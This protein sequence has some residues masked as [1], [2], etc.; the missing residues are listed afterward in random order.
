MNAA[1]KQRH[2]KTTLE[3]VIDESLSTI[4][5][6]DIQ[7][8]AH[9]AEYQRGSKHGHLGGQSDD[10]ITK[11]PRR[12]ALGSLKWT[13]PF[14]E[15]YGAKSALSGWTVF[16]GFLALVIM[17]TFQ[18]QYH[19]MPTP[20]LTDT[21]PVTGQPHFSEGNVRRIVHHLS[22]NIGW[23]LVGT[24]EELE[25]KNYLIHELD[26]L[27][28]Q[29]R[30]HG[31]KHPELTLPKMDI[32]VQVG[33]GS[34]RFDFMS[35]VVM[36]MYTN[37]TNIIVRMS[38]GPE[39][40]KNSI[41]LNAHYDTTLGSPGAVD[42][43]LGIGVMME[44]IRVMSLK[45]APSKNSVV[46]LFNG[47]EESLQ[48]A[49]HSFITNHEL[50]D[51]IRAVINLEG[52]GTT[53]PDILFQANSLEMINA[54][55]KVPY[56]HG[57]VLAND[58]FA[59]GLILSDT[60]FRQFVE[61]GNL[62]G[63]DMAV[64]RNSYLYHTHLD[65]EENME[66]GLPQHMGENTLA[67]VEH[68]AEVPIK[69]MEKTTNVVFFDV[70]GLFFVSYTW[71][72]VL[73]SHLLIAGL[74]A[75]S[76]VTQASRPSIR[77]LLS[78]GPSLFASMVVP[79]VSVAFLQAVDK[80]MIWFSHEW[81]GPLIFGPL[82]IASILFVQSL[83]HNTKQSTGT[84][85]LHV[86]SS[87]QIVYTAVMGL[88]TYYGLASSF[89]VA[90][91]ALSLTVG[92]LYNQR[93]TAMW[94]KDG[95]EVHHVDYSTY[96]V[97]TLV[98]TSYLSY[99]IFSLFDLFIPL[100]GR[101]GVDAPVDLMVAV[102][103]GFVFFSYC[104]PAI[105]LSHRFGRKT[106]R[107]MAAFMLLAHVVI[108]LVTSIALSPFDKMHP[109]RVFVQHLRNMTSGESKLYIAHADPG[110]FY[111]PYVTDL[112]K[113]FGVES[114]YRSGASNPTDWHSIYPFNQFLDSYTLDTTSYIKSRTTNKTIADTTQPLTHFVH[115]APRLYAENISFDPVK[116]TRRLTVLCTHPDYIWTVI[117][118]DT[119]LVSWSL[120]S[121]TPFEYP[122]HY[123]IRHVGGYVSDGWRV[124]LEY[125]ASSIDDKLRVELTALETEGWG[126]DEER[127]L[128]GSGDVGVMRQ[129]RRSSPDWVSITSF[130]AVVQVFEL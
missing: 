61:Y 82:S 38:C 11:K 116:G 52:C 31:L 9:L 121:S 36:K 99:M 50:K 125:K 65:L 64:Y 46:F 10:E 41:L 94:T 24:P 86:L 62:T 124:D 89:V 109:K 29:S 44:I 84:N 103:T 88:A 111:D 100:T 58:L 104:T 55:R 53:G 48:D 17:T 49:S 7:S 128:V 110:A 63:L 102:L 85:E 25:A 28:E 129:I 117:N 70:F 90:M 69:H 123:V 40:D 107:W 76:L 15:R 4:D 60:D 18:L 122:T 108:L 13:N 92:L 73:R 83:F 67:L 87:L 66:P 20:V 30:I 39:C 75:L 59:T 72:A 47:G 45:N 14:T 42:D 6:L 112:E 127:E 35:K 56:P 106:M 51:N 21:D 27:R 19:N 8:I 2:L 115:N 22:S 96:F 93:R 1:L 97:A 113:V 5:G 119:H 32:W 95:P 43:G 120:A 81:L 101:T 78:I 23:R 12:G 16:L 80:S 57:T 3:N 98:P 37:M 130:G 105:A 33:D 91:I 114:S 26:T 118:F 77:A 126:R 34:H 54:Y 68:L 79:I 74:V 71:P